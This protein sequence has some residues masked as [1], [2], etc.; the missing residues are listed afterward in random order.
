MAD[1]C[2]QNI[3]VLRKPGLWYFDPKT[4]SFKYVEFDYEGN[5]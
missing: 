3:D 1:E 2:W 4:F 5:C